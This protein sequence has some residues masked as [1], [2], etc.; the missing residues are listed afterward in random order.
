MTEKQI[1]TLYFITSLQ[2]YEESYEQVKQTLL[3][4]GQLEQAVSSK[5]KG[6]ISSTN[7]QAAV[8]DRKEKKKRKLQD[9]LEVRN[10]THTG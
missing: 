5:R 7:C 9:G 2:S 6:L 8:K 1:S 3:I 4:P 10:Q